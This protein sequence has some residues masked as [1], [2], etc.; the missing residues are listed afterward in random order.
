MR[1]F[2]FDLGGDFKFRP[3]KFLDLELMRIA[4]ARNRQIGREIYPRV[5]EICI[6]RESEFEVEGPKGIQI[7][8]ALCYLVVPRVLDRIREAARRGAQTRDIA[9]LSGGDLTDIA[10]D[11]N[12][13]LWFV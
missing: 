1:G 3:A 11:R 7:S 2:G 4:V 10:L 12:F 6:I 9:K 5:S 8:G 13:F